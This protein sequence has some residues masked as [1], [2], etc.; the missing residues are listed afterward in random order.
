M[1]N[2]GDGLWTFKSKG[3]VN[4]FGIL[5]VNELALSVSDSGWDAV[6]LQLQGG[7]AHVRKVWP[8]WGCNFGHFNFLLQLPQERRMKWSLLSFLLLIDLWDSFHSNLLCTWIVSTSLYSYVNAYAGRVQGV[9]IRC[10]GARQRSFPSPAPDSSASFGGSW[11]RV[12]EFGKRCYSSCSSY[13]FCCSVP[14]VC[15]H[16]P[17]GVL[18]SHELKLMWFLFIS[19]CHIPLP[20]LLDPV[21]SEL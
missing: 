14:C 3:L 18:T 5:T 9:G 19:V 8:P 16:L 6:E 10:W 4:I 21:K 17:L 13:F 7:M 12:L 2:T 20:V 1:Q 15:P 11:F